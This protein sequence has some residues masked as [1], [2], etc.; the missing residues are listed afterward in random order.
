MRQNPNGD[1]SVL[2]CFFEEVLLVQAGLECRLALCLWLWSWDD[3]C[4][5]RACLCGIVCLFI[6][7]VFCKFECLNQ[8]FQ[9]ICFQ[10]TSKLQ[11]RVPITC[12][13]LNVD[14][15]LVCTLLTWAGL[16]SAV[17]SREGDSTRLDCR[18]EGQGTGLSKTPKS[19]IKCKKERR[20][21]Q[22]GI[23]LCYNLI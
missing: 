5:P 22:Q 21:G 23:F 6:I 20:S 14:H 19:E 17:W 13:L 10:R 11:S 18:L 4:G 1:F 3:R 2:L 16:D 9:L 15:T 7:V 8:N 12:M